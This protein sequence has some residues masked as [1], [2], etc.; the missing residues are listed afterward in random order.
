MIGVRKERKAEGELHVELLLV[1]GFVGAEPEHGY[2]QLLHILPGIAHRARLRGAARG[3][4]LRIEVQQHLAALEIGKL[5]GGAVLVR[6][7]K[8]GCLLAR[9]KCHVHH[10]PP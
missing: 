10:V 5:Y 3:V 9:G 1:C 7:G 4:R 6:E 2:V 8:S